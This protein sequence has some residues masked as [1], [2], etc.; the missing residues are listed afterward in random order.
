MPLDVLFID[1]NSPDGT[2]EVL[3][4]LAQ[5]NSCLTYLSRSSKQGIGSAHKDGIA[6]AYEKG[7][8]ILVAMDSDFTHSPQDIPRM[9]QEL[10]FA[11]V[12][13]GSRYLQTGSLPGWNLFRRILTW[14]GHFLT[15]NLLGLPHDA[16][17]AFRC[18]NLKKIPQETFQIV[19][20]NSY[21]F[22][23]E[24]LFILRQNGM[25]IC[26]IPIVLTA[27]TY[28][29]SKMRVSDALQSVFILWKIFVK[30]ITTPEEFLVKHHRTHTKSDLKDPQNWD[31][32]WNRPQ[33]KS[34]FLYAFIAT[35]YRQLVIK[36][37][38]NCWIRDT[39]LPNSCL[40]HAGC[41]SGQVDRDL[42]HEMRLTAIDISPSALELYACNNPR[43]QKI[44]HASIF[45]LPYSKEYF[46]GI[47]NLGVMEHFTEEEI[48]RI[49]SEFHRVLAHDGR[50]VLFW[51]H[52]WA[53][54]VHVLRFVRFLI[55]LF[56]NK[57]VEFHP[58][59]ITYISGRKMAS[60]ILDKAGF[61]LIAYS[62][63]L[64]D[65]FVQAVLVARKK[66]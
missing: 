11:D 60:K 27:R 51:P 31:A 47:Y 21:S 63:T 22:F 50:I 65:F 5:E 19:K 58:A 59:E 33:T 25:K 26:E 16:S 9:I 3:Q 17:G 1:D 4:S 45:A 32:Y 13:V 8:D 57:T 35:V 39:F 56:S 6:Y 37:N 44:E 10:Q 55:R 49:L 36:R 54:S 66:Q 18:Y 2:G 40:L 48:F 23:F 29:H 34:G 53:T 12:S 42:Q 38:L 28:G 41:G 24:T 30:R 64:S 14:T 43:V 62:F 46:E 7:Y 15:V 20:S 61:E 52:R